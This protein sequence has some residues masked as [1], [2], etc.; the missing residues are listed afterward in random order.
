MSTK[1]A[2]LQPLRP[3]AYERLMTDACSPADLHQSLTADVAGHRIELLFDGGD[4]LTRLLDLINGA[5]HSIDLIMYIFKG[6]A[7]GR[8]ILD[9]MLVAAKRGVRV[10][11]VIDSFG[12]GDTP[13]SL[14]ASLR[15]AGGS[16][17]FFSRRWRSTYLIRNHQKLILIDD[18]IA[19]T[20]GFNIADD[21]LSPPRSDCWFDIGMIVKGPTVIQAARWFAEIHDYTVNDD[22]KVLTL[23]RLI[24]EWPVDGEA[25]SWLV[26]GPTQRLS[27]WARA[28]RADL[29]DA[30][31]LD[32]A[33]AYFSPGQGMLRRL[34]RV[35]RRGR[36][37]FVMAGKS[38]NPATIGASR[39]L[40]GYL[41]RKTGE[42]WEYRPCRLHMKLIV[43]DD[44]VYIGSA[45]FD[46]RS[47]FVNVEVMVRIAD[48]GFAE[49]MRNFLAALRPDCE[50]ITSQSHKARGSWLT[51]LRWT[52]AWFVV[53]VV[54]Y[55]V[56][57][58][59]NFGLGDPDPEV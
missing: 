17:T 12:S 52:L 22:G 39:L 58:K 8:R 1:A 4:R 56:S 25:V 57:R 9:A 36:A 7:A 10:R 14:F 55:T 23:R 16:V 59:L 41:L 18:Y 27:P 35:A 31:Q 40:Y 37:R 45:N 15:E 46:V 54:D 20:G 2:L 53:G 29:D 19:V 30:R 42:V 24:R 5:A 34:G 21:Y 6:D 28:V 43:I 51:R 11:A 3:Q 49:R 44:V 13:D 48:A 26:G 38:D 32:M 33:M 50:I 47:L